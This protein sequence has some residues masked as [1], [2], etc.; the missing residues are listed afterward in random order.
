MQSFL[1]K[2]P[3]PQH[4]LSCLRALQRVEASKGNIFSSSLVRIL[5]NST[6]HFNCRCQDGHMQL[7][8][9]EVGKEKSGASIRKSLNKDLPT[10][11]G[12]YQVYLHDSKKSYNL[13]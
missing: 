9:F 1:F 10:Q 8:H 11:Q 13:L 4:F 3:P 2:P 5:K 12:F 7:L 6:I